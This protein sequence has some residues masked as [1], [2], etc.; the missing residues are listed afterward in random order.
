MIT[1]L[2]VILTLTNIIGCITGNSTIKFL[3][4]YTKQKP[5]FDVDGI[6]LVVFLIV[7]VL[8]ILNLAR[9]IECNEEIEKKEVINEKN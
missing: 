9:Y 6:T 5:M 7:E 1:K 3:S 4:F 2:L 8:V